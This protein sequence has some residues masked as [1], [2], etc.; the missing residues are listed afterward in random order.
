M[1]RVFSI[2]TAAIVLAG[3]VGC[4]SGCGQSVQGT[5]E[6]VVVVQSNQEN[7]TVLSFPA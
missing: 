3:V 6:K 2:I 4:F 5:D 1:R 7:N